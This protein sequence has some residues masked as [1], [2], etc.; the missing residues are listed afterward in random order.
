MTAKG[1]LRCRFY[2]PIL[3]ITLLFSAPLQAESVLLQQWRTMFSLSHSLMRRVATHR[4]SRGDVSGAERAKCIAEKLE[5]GLGL[6]SWRGIWSMGWDYA[7]TYAWGDLLSGR[8]RMEIFRAVSDVNELLGALNELTQIN[9]AEKRAKWVVKNYRKVLGVSQSLLQRL[10]VEYGHSGP[11][12]DMV[13]MLQKEAL[14]GNLL[15]DCL[16]VGANDLKGLLQ[17]VKEISSNTYSVSS[18]GADDDL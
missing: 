11:L 8:P 9:S 17:I 12:R 5:L 3:L 6:G 16:E 4:A 10:L 14:E 7:R 15:K 18:S 2:R 13:L 1:L